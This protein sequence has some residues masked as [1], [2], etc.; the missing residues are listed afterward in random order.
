MWIFSRTLADC[1]L[2]RQEE[3]GR[4]V[5]EAALLFKEKGRMRTRRTRREDENPPGPYLVRGCSSSEAS[6]VAVCKNSRREVGRC[7]HRENRG[8]N[9]PYKSILSPFSTCRH[10]LC[11]SKISGQ[12]G[13]CYEPPS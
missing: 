12:K 8:Q 2:Q 11:P 5:P 7:L 4:Y 10:T 3:R 9:F 1:W 6:I 13:G